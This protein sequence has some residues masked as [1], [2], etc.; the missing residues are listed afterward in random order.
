MNQG[1]W[2]I[3]LM[4]WVDQ[5][6]LP[7]GLQDQNFKVIDTMLYVDRLSPTIKIEPGAVE[8]P[9]SLFMWEASDSNTSPYYTASLPMGGYTLRFQP[10]IPI[11]FRTVKSMDLHL[12]D[13]GSLQ[14]LYASAW[15]YE[16]QK[17]VRIPLT[18]EHTNVPEASRYVGP[19]GEVKLRVVS[20]QGNMAQ[21]TASN[22]TLV[23]EP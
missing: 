20:N 16:L 8:L 12:A 23:V 22:I 1:N 21:V 7:V 9:T 4:G 5:I 11:A 3:Y 18:G 6:E 2:G 14:N 10:A 19:D 15:D 13:N 17:W